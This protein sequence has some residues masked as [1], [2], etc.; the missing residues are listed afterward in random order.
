MGDEVLLQQR[1]VVELVQHR[2]LLYAAWLI[3]VARRSYC[4]HYAPFASDVVTAAR[5]AT[6]AIEQFE[7]DRPLPALAQLLAVRKLCNLQVMC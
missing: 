5:S 7:L 2:S 6:A 3:P 1:A 4:Y